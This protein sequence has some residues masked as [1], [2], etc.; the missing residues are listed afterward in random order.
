MASNPQTAR[1]HRL[2]DEVINASAPDTFATALARLL[3]DIAEDCHGAALELESAW[4]EK[5]A[6]AQ[7]TKLAKAIDAAQRRIEKTV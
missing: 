3:H 1:L 4:Q 5:G 2:L 6:G 7:W